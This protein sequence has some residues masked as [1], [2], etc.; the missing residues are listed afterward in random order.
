M[1]ETEVQSFITK[2]FVR[3]D[4]AFARETADAGRAILWE[5]TGCDQNDP[6]TWRKPAVRP[7]IT[8]GCPFQWLSTLRSFTTPSTASSGSNAGFPERALGLSPFGFPRVF[9]S[10]RTPTLALIALTASNSEERTLIWKA[11]CPTSIVTRY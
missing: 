11:P 1:T 2:S 7:A 8:V 6:A 5:R 4:A 10:V 9:A 3:I